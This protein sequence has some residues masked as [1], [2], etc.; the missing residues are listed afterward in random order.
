MPNIPSEQTWGLPKGSDQFV[1]AFARG[2]A[3]I[4]AFGPGHQALTLSE[5]AERT[6]L[7]PAGARRLLY[8]LVTLGYARNEERRFSLTPAVLELGYAYLSSLSWRDIARH[9]VEA[10]MRDTG[11]ICTVS[12]LDGDDV[13]Y[14]ARAEM[15]SP[16][17]RRLGVGERLPTHATSSGHVLLAGASAQEREAFLARAPFERHTQHTLIDA[18]PLRRAIDDAA[19]AGYALA[20]EQL[21]LGIC[22]LAVPILDERGRVVAAL[23]TSLNLAR[24]D[25]GE[26][27]AKFCPKLRE[28]AAQVGQAL[29]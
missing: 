26:I 20:S 2:L 5:V 15:P 13:V 14:V 29:G 9:A 28:A 24:H 11:E 19:A 10:F 7:T 21:E 4:R 12:V 6:G 1:E 18:A 17:S 22:G 3:V 25:L 27:P 8:T 16:L 23:T